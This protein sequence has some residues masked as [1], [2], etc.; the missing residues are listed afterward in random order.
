MLP[1]WGIRALFKAQSKLDVCYLMFDMGYSPL[2]DRSTVSSSGA[3]KE[4]M[5]SILKMICMGI[6]VARMINHAV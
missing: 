6:D 3:E 2:L 1:H 4:S 5:R